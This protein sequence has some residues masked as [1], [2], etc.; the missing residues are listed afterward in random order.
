MSEWHPPVEC[1]ACGS[2]DTRL[3]EPRYE[4]LIYE[5]NICGLRFETEVDD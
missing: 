1:P 4:M 5:C 3:V 2:K